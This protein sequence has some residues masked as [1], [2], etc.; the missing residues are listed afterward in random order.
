MWHISCVFSACHL[1][2]S[3]FPHVPPS[4]D[5]TQKARREMATNP[6][7]D[8][9][10]LEAGVFDTVEQ[11]RCAVEALLAAGFRPDQITVVCSDEAKKRHFAD[12]EREEPAGTISPA[13]AAAGGAAGAV[14]GGLTVFVSAVATG[15]L[16]LWAAG[17][18]TAWAGGVAGGL[19]GAMM[20]RGVEKELANFYQQ[21]VREGRIL[22]GV[23]EQDPGS[24]QK[25]L[26]AAEILHKCGSPALPLT[27]G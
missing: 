8:N 13:A 22:I 23:E 17:P 3:Q 18:I 2:C 21:A 10:Q 9:K 19:I 24:A 15:G 20:S 25:L 11:A 26:D 5:P 7:I 16:A 6:I 27:E 4:H 1:K 12:V 14:L